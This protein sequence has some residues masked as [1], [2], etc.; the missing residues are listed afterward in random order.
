MP[1]HFP[2]HRYLGPGTKDMNVEPID[3]DDSIAKEHDHAYAKANNVQDIDKADSHAISDFI[4]N[5]IDTG[6]WHSLVGA[7]GLLLKNPMNRFIP[8]AYQPKSKQDI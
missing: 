7:T 6:N 2:W 1:I 4:S 5:F 8:Y 3:V